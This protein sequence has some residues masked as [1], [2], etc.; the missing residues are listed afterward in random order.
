MTLRGL[1]EHYWFKICFGCGRSGNTISFLMEHEKYS[2]VEALRFL[3]NRYNVEI[4]ETEVSPE[5]KQ[6]QQ[7]A[8]SLY[9]IN[10]QGDIVDRW[11]D[12]KPLKDDVLDL[13]DAAAGRI[14]RALRRRPGV[15]DFPW[16]M[17]RLMGREPRAVGVCAVNTT[18]PSVIVTAPASMA[19]RISK[20]LAACTIGNS[21]SPW[22]PPS[23]SSTSAGHCQPACSAST[24]RT[25]K[26]SSAH[27][28]LPMPR[29]TI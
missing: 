18:P 9:I 28:R 6:Q 21:A 23:T 25:P 26:P 11:S 19:S 7:V 5:Q 29:M 2:Y 14:L 12:A 10:T 15:Y 1:V 8:D 13:A 17:R 20:W 3:A 27:S 22:V 24:A 4:E 16:A